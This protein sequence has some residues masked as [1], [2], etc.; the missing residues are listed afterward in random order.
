[1]HHL[2]IHTASIAT[3]VETELPPAADP[4]LT[5]QNG[6]ILPQR[7]FPLLFAAACGATLQRSRISTPT[8]LQ[9][10]TPFLRPLAQSAN[11]GM[12][13]R[14][15]NLSS[16]RL[17]LK[18]NEEVVVYATQTSAGAEREWVALGFAIDNALSISGQ[19][20]T[21][22]GTST[23]AAVAN[24]WTQITV[25]WQN[26]LPQGTYVVGGGEHFSSNGLAWRAIFTDQV[27]RP[28][29]LSVTS[30]GNASADIFRFGN[31]GAWGRFQNY[32]FPNIEV[33]AGAADATHE[34]YLDLFRVG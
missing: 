15:A 14:V 28:G 21:L 24:A 17:V 25:T 11:F 6:H 3:G 5:I 8:L 12:P 18:Q 1:M 10:T 26:Q 19:P 22:R 33:F 31:L 29:G 30:L 7:D 16:D 27:Y 34:I 20:Y 4:V 13:Q 23:T 2:A 32:Q 9:T